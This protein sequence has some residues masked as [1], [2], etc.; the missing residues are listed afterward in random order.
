LIII[1]NDNRVVVHAPMGNNS[2]GSTSIADI[3]GGSG[4]T[5]KL[6]PNKRIPA[7]DLLNERIQAMAAGSGLTIIF[8]GQARRIGNFPEYPSINITKFKS[9]VASARI[10]QPFSEIIPA[11]A[12]YEG[13]CPAYA[14]KWYIVY[15]ITGV[16]TQGDINGLLDNVRNSIVLVQSDPNG[17]NVGGL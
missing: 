6:A 4:S 3:E 14:V 10:A 15:K 2:M 12:G 17:V 9:L 13:V 11:S 8:D 16:R 5:V 1:V 7:S